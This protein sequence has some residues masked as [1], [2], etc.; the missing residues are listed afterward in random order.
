M[1][2]ILLL[3]CFLISG[4]NALGEPIQVDPS[5]D[6][7]LDIASFAQDE[8]NRR[9]SSNSLYKTK[10]VEVKN[11]QKK[12][13]SGI[14]YDFDVLTAVTLCSINDATKP[15]ECEINPRGMKE[16]CSVTV[17]VKPWLNFREIQPG[18]KCTPAPADVTP[19]QDDDKPLNLVHVPLMKD[20]K[21]DKVDL[22]Y[23]DAFKKWLQKYNKD[24]AT[25]P[26]LVRYRYKIFADNM[27]TIEEYQKNEQGTA[28]YGPTKFAD[29]TTDEFKKYLGLSGPMKPSGKPMKQATIPNIQEPDAFDWRD[30][31]AVSEVKD[32][33][34]CGS[35]WAF[36][37]TGNIEGQWAIKKNKL[38]S[39][40]EQEL[41]DCDKID[42]G[43]DGGL[44]SQ[45]Y[46]E[47]IRLGGLESE[48]A[49]PYKG[50]WSDNCT[51]DR[52]KV[53]VYINSS[54]NISKDEGDMAK[55]LAKNGP[56]SIGIN[57][58]MMQFYF[59]GISHPYKIFCEP[60]KLDHGVLIVGYGVKSD[61]PY[62]IV[63]NSWG[64]DWGVKG[65][66]LVYRGDGVCGLNQMCTSAVIE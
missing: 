7:A 10:V 33:G 52:S 34:M 58:N 61:K 49:Y 6:E 15:E 19:S 29:L 54:V 60:T 3:V 57:A 31:N 42:E 20:T 12:L 22:S 32:Q 35:C 47:I 40:S 30:H 11:V 63:K 65:Y 1:S 43:C 27:K 59:G 39:L 23:M 38:I 48:K 50:M 17:W 25:E 36:S 2:S 16:I 14:L 26:D 44:P 56:I 53:E 4:I 9:S 41:V 62:W 51:F 8:L 18:L 28:V 64:D 5:S 66:Y 46:E 24:Y 55:W 45:A 13:V 21:E 37:T